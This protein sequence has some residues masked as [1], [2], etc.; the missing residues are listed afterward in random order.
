VTQAGLLENLHRLDTMVVEEVAKKGR[1][2]TGLGRRTQAS[3]IIAKDRSL[4]SSR[5]SRTFWAHICWE[6]P[7][8][9]KTF[10]PVSSAAC[11]AESTTSSR[12]V[13]LVVR[14][15]AATASKTREVDEWGDTS[16]KEQPSTWMGELGGVVLA[17]Q[18]AA[19]SEDVLLLCDNESVF[20]VIQ[21]WVGHGGKVT[22]DTAPDADILQQLILLPRQRVRA[23]RTTFLVKVKSHRGEPINERADTLA[24]EGRE[25]S[26]VKPRRNRNMA[27]E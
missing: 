8:V 9:S 23:G 21:K 20:R 24:E 6:E 12:S 4:V 16:F 18:T 1:N 11:A 2:F 5:S 10:M 14:H 25:M 22:L 3:W 13:I 26:N 17:L 7:W 19:L 15:V 27:E